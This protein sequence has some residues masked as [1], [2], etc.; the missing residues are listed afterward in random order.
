[1]IGVSRQRFFAALL[2]CVVVVAIP[3][4]IRNFRSISILNRAVKHGA[5]STVQAMLKA[6]PELV[7]A[8]DSRI[9]ATPLH[10]AVIRNHS[11]IAELLIDKGADVNAVDKFGMTPLHKAA[12]FNRKNMTKLLLSKGADSDIMGVKWGVFRMTPLHLAAEAGFPDV[13]EVLLSSGADINSR[14]GGTN[15]VTPLHIAAG[16]DNW[17]VTELLL[18]NGAEVNTKDSNG[19]TPLEWAISSNHD[20]VADLLRLYGGI[21]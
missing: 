15:S 12:S 21:R 4:I 8:K 13:V 7:N 9:G 3:F 5:L 17:H 11:D 10:W 18:K 19:K 14:T 6:H 2:I 1:M 16:R 20:E